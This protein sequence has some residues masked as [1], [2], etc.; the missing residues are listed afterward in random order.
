MSARAL[1][2]ADAVLFEGYLLYPYRQ[3]SVKNRYR[4]SFGVIEP[5]AATPEPGGAPHA[6]GT[7][8]L[9]V[10]A[11]PEVRLRLRFLQVVSRQIEVR[12]KGGTW[13]TWEQLAIDGVLHEGGLEAEPREVELSVEPARDEGKTHAKL[14]LPPRFVARALGAPAPGTEA[15][16]LYSYAP[17]DVS[18]RAECLL[19]GPQM[20][21]LRATVENLSTA[22]SGLATRSDVLPSALASTQLVAWVECGEFVSL[23][24]PPPYAREAASACRSQGLYPVLLGPPEARD[25]MLCAPIILEDHAT[26]APESPVDLFDATEIDEILTLRTLALTPEEKAQARATDARASALILHIEGLG[27]R[28]FEALHG[29]VRERTHPYAAGDRVRLVGGNR[30]TDAQDALYAGR[31]ATVEAVKEDVDGQTLLAVTIDDDPAQELHRWYG[32]F[33]YYYTDEVE[34]LGEATP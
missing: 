10:G 23:R 3:S 4:F 8:L 16:L 21:R 32:R 27:A 19:V 18:V 14:V 29:A 15:R 26:I 9:L 7:D 11:S 28:D 13:H 20:W 30:R 25:A 31:T 22:P 17:L 24:D 2:L 12:A 1:A 6:L 33:H 34:P 5:R